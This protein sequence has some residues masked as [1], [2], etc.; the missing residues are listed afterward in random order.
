MGCGASIPIK[1]SGKG[2]KRRSVIQEV[3]VFVPTIRVPEDT[4]IVNPLRGLVSKELVDRLAALRANVVSLSEEIYHG[5]TSAVSELQRAL[6]EYLPIVL[7]LAIKESRLEA[8][9]KFS[10]RTLDDDQECVL[11]SAWY[12]VLSVVHMMAMLALFEANLL[13]IPRNVQDGSE[14]KVSE[15]AKKDVVDSLLRASGC[16]DYCVHR[17]LVQIPAQI[18][19]SFPSYLQEGMLE[20]ISIQALA[21]CVQIQLGLA[22]ECDKATLSVKRRLACEQVSYFSQA[23]YCLSGCDTSDSYGKK[24]LLFLKW[25]CMD[26]KAVAYYYHALVLD[27]GSEP[28]NHISSVCCLS[29]ADDLLAESK[30]ACLSFCLANPITRVP[31]PW[32]IMKNMHKK[33]PDVAYKKFQ[34]YGHLLEQNKNSALQSLPDLPEFPLS[35]RPEGYEFPITDSI[36]ENVDCQPQ[37]QSLKEHLK[38]DE[39]VAE[40]K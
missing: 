5:D 27:K 31:P 28:S 24:L 19:K 7:G 23:H 12:E 16:L 38:D 4:D 40:T 35:L 14:R 18:K 1:Y 39:E 8:S 10:W 33:I 25:K 29:A 20:A 34:I 21:Q 37:I 36:W 32:G 30:R 17:I 3:A 9:V 11:A 2:R 13:L 15:D 6:E 22:S 26:A